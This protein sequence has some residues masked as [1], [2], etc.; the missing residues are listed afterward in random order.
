MESGEFCGV[1]GDGIGRFAHSMAALFCGHKRGIRGESAGP[2]G[3]Q[4]VYY[5]AKA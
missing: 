4:L 5:S 3:E 2:Y 1:G